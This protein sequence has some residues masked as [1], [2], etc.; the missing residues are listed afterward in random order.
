M[1]DNQLS[2]ELEELR[3]EIHF[4]N[5]RYHVLDEPLIS[6]AEFDQK[7]SR[8]KE[9]EQQHPEWV[10]ADS[11]SQRAGAKPADKFEKVRH[12]GAILSLA[13]VHFQGG[14]SVLV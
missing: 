7:L 3:R 4:H 1:T 12:P 11:P 5:Y 2:L 8:L 14:C 10:T 6:D 9:I 13:S